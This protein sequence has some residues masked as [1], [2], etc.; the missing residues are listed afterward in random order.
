MKL[1]KQKK[2]ENWTDRLKKIG[3]LAEVEF[4]VILGMNGHGVSCFSLQID[5]GVCVTVCVCV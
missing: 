1:I 5:T 2:E 4:G 3:T